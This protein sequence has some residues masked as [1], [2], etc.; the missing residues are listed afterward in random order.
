MDFVPLLVGAAMVAVIVDVL[1]SARGK[2]WN[3]VLTPLVAVG[4]GILVTLLLANSDFAGSI[5]LGDTGFTLDNVNTASLILFGFAFGSVA[6]KGVDALKAIDGS[7]SQKRP[8][9]IED[10]N[11]PA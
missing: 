5:E 7:D 9:L 3:G 1:R 6:A 10:G 4:A 11:P 2:D 8:S